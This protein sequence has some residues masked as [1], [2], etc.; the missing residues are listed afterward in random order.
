MST[1]QRNKIREF[2]IARRAEQ[3]KPPFTEYKLNRKIEKALNQFHNTV[4][5]QRLDRWNALE[6]ARA[7]RRAA[8]IILEEGSLR[9]GQDRTRTDPVGEVSV[10]RPTMARL[11]AVAGV[12]QVQHA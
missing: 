2:L 3:G 1:Q 5:R 9:Y 11:T 12:N 10:I 6:A 7:D 4:G 8:R